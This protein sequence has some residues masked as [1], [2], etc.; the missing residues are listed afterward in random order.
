MLQD[1]AAALRQARL[2]WT[3]G[4]PP[5]PPLSLPSLEVG[6][7]SAG[8]DGVY[9]PL[10]GGEGLGH[11]T[12]GWGLGLQGRCVRGGWSFSTTLLGLRDRGH[13]SGVLQR[14][15]LAYQT[16]SGWRV[17]LEQAPFAWG[18]G[19][20]GGDLLGDVA[21][22]FPRLSLTTSEAALPLGRWRAEAFA[23]RLE[24]NRPIP[25]WTPDREARITARAAEF[26]L[27]KPIL[28][29]GFL[30][31]SFATQVEAS[32]G[33][34]VMEGGQD[35]QGHAAPAASARTMSLAEV[36]VRIPALAHFV[37]AR[38]AS[39]YVS[40][41]SAP[42]RRAMTL[43]PSRDLGG[44]QL[45]WDGWDLGFEYA[46]ATPQGTPTTFSQPAYLAGFSTHGDPMG[47]AFRRDAI[48]RTVELGLPLC[49]EGQ[50]RIK[51]VRATV[52]L[53]PSTGTGS[54]FVQADAW[55]RTP[56]GRVGASVA[57]RR[58]EFPGSNV[59][60]GWAFSVFQ[61]FRVF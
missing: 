9:T 28:W 33:S 23:G 12:Q 31:A 35:A 11:G 61:S 55:W 22:P 21:R 7:G 26:D 19:L 56:T 14:A 48:T 44:G 18:S 25:Q 57:S 6:W 15:A 3:L 32:F 27:Q 46:G 37:R 54:W 34:V 16:E 8:S 39:V 50:G 1:G 47:S 24:G 60:W 17:A 29:G 36:R 13:T 40:R 49:L 52:A 45:V 41:S 20:N 38:G 42:E 59:R 53:D 4:Q 10:T 2:D 5:L 58:D 30:R 43:A 51:A